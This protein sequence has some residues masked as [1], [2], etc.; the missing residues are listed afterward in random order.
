M[1]AIQTTLGSSGSPSTLTHVGVA[2]FSS[3]ITAMR[4]FLHA[5]RSSG[6]IREIVDFDSPFIVTEPKRLTYMPGAGSR[7]FT[8]FP[9][10]RAGTGWVTVTP[11]HFEHV[12]AYHQYR[13]PVLT[14][15]RI[16]WMMYHQAMITSSI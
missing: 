8:Q 5:M 15:A 7:C 2:S 4:L 14:H 9:L 12:A 6:L 3:G 13:E 16:G 1:N 11:Q 10:A